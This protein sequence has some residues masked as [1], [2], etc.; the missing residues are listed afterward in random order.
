ME[1]PTPPLPDSFGP[2]SRP[3]RGWRFALGTGAVVGALAA[4]A[5]G[6][7]VSLAGAQAGVV[8]EAGSPTLT[9]L[10]LAE[11][12]WGVLIHSGSTAR[13]SDSLMTDGGIETAGSTPT[14]EGNVLGYAV[15]H[16]ALYVE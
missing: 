14:I 13:V 15:W 11:N 12:E 16:P 4:T 2:P 10:V 1:H 6:S 5:F 9:D 7:G 8:V 3:R